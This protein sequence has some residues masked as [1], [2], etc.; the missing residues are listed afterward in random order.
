LQESSTFQVYNASAGSGK[1]FKLVKEYLKILLNSSDI[2]AF[3]KVLAITFTNK[4][5]GEMKERVLSSL[6]AFSE[7][8][9]N[10]LLKIILKEIAVDKT[11]IQIRSKKILETIL[12]NY[13][14]FSITTIDSFTHKIIKNFA[15]DLG[16][17]LNFEV[18]MDTDSLLHEAVDVLISKIGTDK[19]LT[20]ILIDYSL[21]KTD[22]D[23]SWD[24]TKELNEFSSILLKEEDAKHFKNLESK[25]LDDF[26]E[27]KNKLT[28]KNKHIEKQF[29]KLAD[30]VLL[31]IQ[32]NNLTD[33]DFSYSDYPNHFKKLKNSNFDTLNFE[34]RLHKN[35]ESQKNLYGGKASST[36][37]NTLD[38]LKEI[39]SEYYFLS[40]ELA[41]RFLA[42]YKVHK[43]ALK[44]I[45]PLAVLNNINQELETIKIENNIRLNAEFNQLISDKIK[46]QPA[47]FIYERIG[48]RFQNYFIDEMQ[49][50]SILQW[51]NLIPLIENALSQEQGSL[52]L[53]GD[54]KQA[55]YRWRGGKASQFINLGSE[56]FQPFQ[57]KKSLHSLE[58]N[59]RSYDEI[60]HFNN[61][62]FTFLGDFLANESYKNLFLEGNSQQENK[63]KGGFVSISF[64]EKEQVEDEF[65][66]ENQTE[67]KKSNYPKYV[68]KKINELKE[69]F[70]LN[71]ICVL[72]RKKKDGI[73]I[74]NFLQEKNIP[75][76]SSE[77]L[78]IKNNEKV[79]FI[80]NLL[81]M[82]QNP[83]DEETRFEFL[84]FLHQHLSI[85]ISKHEFFDSFIKSSNNHIFR[86]LKE[87]NITFDEITFQQ[88]SFYEKIEE[89]IRSFHLTNSSDA[90]IQYFLDVILEQQN[91]GNDSAGFLEFWEI[92]KESLSIVAPESS[93]AVQI[94]TIHKSKGL[95]FLVVLFP[96]DVDIYK[97]IKPKVWLD[98]LPEMYQPFSELLVDYKNDFQFINS[99]SLAIYNHQREELE[100]DNFNLL[101]VALTRAVEQLHI[102]TGNKLPK[103]EK[104]KPT[105][106][107]SFF[108][109]FLKRQNHWKEGVLDYSFGQKLRASHQ[110]KEMVTSVIHQKFISIPWKEQNLV[111]LASASKLWDTAQG[112]AIEFGNLI[113]EMLSK[114]I[115]FK[116]VE[117]VLNS[118]LKEG[119]VSEIEKET[120]RKTIDSIV[121]HPSLHQYFSEDVIVFNEREI[122]DS[123]KQI[124]IPDRLVF[125]NNYEVVIIDYKT[126]NQI[127][128]HQQQLSKY[129]NVLKTMNLRVQEKLLIYIGQ[130][131]EVVKV[132][133]RV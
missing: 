118:Y 87:F 77:T 91:K 15:Y 67:S 38:E 12:Q 25:T 66:N 110:K 51:Q 31:L 102:I 79:A 126:G 80:V 2:F 96:C 63:K 4:A 132:D 116:E 27:L 41:N 95:E 93:N 53:V 99:T 131:I 33:D 109:D 117:K 113:H 97:Q 84:Y 78:L 14:A 50:T 26:Y 34:G 58:T 10:E 82:I 52:L 105:V 21:D 120:I 3:Q 94:M 104:E 133:E 40:K 36:A 65:E 24:I 35:I 28:V 71:E 100:L 22:E 8:K 7:G 30:E 92:K 106:F 123:E 103:H 61:S 43:L 89:I 107:S 115:S 37:K 124:I 49:D 74:A 128:E 59:Y 75:I 47:P 60:V 55:I 90:Y 54:G 98:N 13:S 129:E 108:V 62:F 86:R 6:K 18:E 44:S 19:K 45:I 1:T 85:K 121:F 16:L 57:V 64:I 73:E 20:E 42:D 130:K 5:A 112:K 48:Q 23:S 127:P 17:T 114:I 32:N 111:L 69:Q 29:N 9:D 122:V 125:K 68:F 88:F 11:I 70:S 83:E 81:K 56:H 72:T 39:F 119:Y 46:D 101:Y 76:I